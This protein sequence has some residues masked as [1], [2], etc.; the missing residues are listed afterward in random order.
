MCLMTF[1]KKISMKNTLSMDSCSWSL[2]FSFDFHTISKMLT[3]TLWNPVK[4]FFFLY[5]PSFEPKHITQ[6]TNIWQKGMS[7]SYI[8]DGNRLIL[9]SKF[10]LILSTFSLSSLSSW[11]IVRWMPVFVFW[12]PYLREN[13]WWIRAHPSHPFTLQVKCPWM[14]VIILYLA[15]ERSPQ[16]ICS[17]HRSM[18]I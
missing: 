18:S 11:W 1:S 9:R 13:K 15:W 10:K 6:R 8:S 2:H 16:R 12:S 3:W 17:C 14:Y 4:V 7:Q 5:P